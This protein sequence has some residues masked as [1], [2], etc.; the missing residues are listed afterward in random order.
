MNKRAFALALILVMVFGSSFTSTKQDAVSFKCLIQLKNYGGEGAYVV[1][2][3]LDPEG[4]Y[5]ETLSVSGDDEEWYEDM[6]EW[7]EFQEAA[8]EDIDGLI[9]ASIASGGRKI[10]VMEVDRGKLEAGYKLRFETAVE[11][12]DYFAADVEVELTEGN[13]KKK[14]EGSGFIRYVQLIQK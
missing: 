13:V 3:L 7:W 14:L 12:Q 9:G 10:T 8:N 1:L 5:V 6:P 2:S 4:N 11:D